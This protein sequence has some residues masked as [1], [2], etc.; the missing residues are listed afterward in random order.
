MMISCLSGRC[1]DA[2][3]R[4]EELASLADGALRPIVQLNTHESPER[5]PGLPI[6]RQQ[7]RGAKVD[8]ALLTATLLI[9]GP[10]PENPTN[11]HRVACDS[12]PGA[13]DEGGLRILDRSGIAMEASDPFE[14]FPTDSMLEI[15][16][17]TMSIIAAIQADRYGST[18]T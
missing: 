12:F 3:K 16:K 7:Y 8:R 13:R 10:R 11:D 15:P 14:R 18:I 9:V 4:S 2:A 5:F 1:Q 17:W 6:N